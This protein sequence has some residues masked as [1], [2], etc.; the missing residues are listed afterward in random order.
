MFNPDAA[1]VSF[2][3]PSL[4]TA[5]RSLKVAPI[6]APVHRAGFGILH[7]AISGISA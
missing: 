3:M 6:I 5:A 1:P 4:E 7:R 2:F